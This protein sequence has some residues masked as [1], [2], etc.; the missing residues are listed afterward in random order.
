[1]THVAQDI[2]YGTELALNSMNPPEITSEKA[3]NPLILRLYGRNDSSEKWTFIET[4]ADLPFSA[5]KYD[6]LI[7][8]KENPLKQIFPTISGEKNRVFP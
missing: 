1:M 4:H 7:A 5:Q 6:P 8:V 2:F 3:Y